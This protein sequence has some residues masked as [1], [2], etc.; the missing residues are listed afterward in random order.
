MSKL[1]NL[2][3][4]LKNDYVSKI[5][6]TCPNC[7]QVTSFLFTDKN[8]AKQDIVC[9]NCKKDLS[10]EFLTLLLKEE[11]AHQKSLR[12]FLITILVLALL[13]LVFVITYLS[14]NKANF[15]VY[16]IL[17]LTIVIFLIALYYL[18]KVF[19]TIKNI[20]QIQSKF[21]LK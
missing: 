4:S 3:K 19:K 6:V 11:L 16:I 17:I 7:G 12:K 1:S 15:G 2:R 14:L 5:E 13:S 8:I 18:I 9:K 20:K 10:S 21:Q